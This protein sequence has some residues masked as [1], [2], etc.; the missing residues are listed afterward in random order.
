MSARH[1]AGHLTGHRT[2]RRID[3]GDG[4]AALLRRMVGV[5]VAWLSVLALVSMVEGWAS[6]A[7][8]ALVAAVMGVLGLVAGHVISSAHH[9]PHRTGGAH[10]RRVNLPR[11]GYDGTT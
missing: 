10:A 3:E 2:G 1:L 4:T 8:G 6:V 9:E 7:S 11:N 5:G